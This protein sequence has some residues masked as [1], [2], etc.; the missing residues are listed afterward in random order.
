MCV[1]FRL[2]T[3]QSENVT[4]KSEHGQC[5]SHLNAQTEALR[6]SFREQVRHLQ[7]EH[8]STVE[9]LQQQIGRLETQL[10]HMQKE[11]SSSGEKS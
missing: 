1:S 4:L 5:T 10:F 3:L 2:L 9:T 7:D 8:C 11:S 6:N